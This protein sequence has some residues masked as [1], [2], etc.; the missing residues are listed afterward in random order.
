MLDLIKELSRDELFHFRK[1]AN[2][3]Y[4]NSNHHVAIVLEYFCSKYRG[5]SVEFPS[6]EFVFNKIFPGEKYNDSKFRKFTSDFAQAMEKFL[7]QREFDSDPV[8]NNV[9]LLKMLRLRGMK[10][11]FEMEYKKILRSQSKRFSRDESYYRNQTDL[12][13][14]YYSLNYSFP[15]KKIS[16]TLQEKSD[17]VDL[18]FIFSKLHCFNEMID[19]NLRLNSPLKFRLTFFDDVMNYVEKN[20]TEI[21]KKHPNVYIIYLR[22]RMV[23][24]MDDKYFLRLKIFLQEK[25][26]KFTNEKLC[27]YYNYIVSYLWLKINSGQIKYREELFKLYN[28][29][30]EKNLFLIDNKISE[31]EFTSVV[32][33]VLPLKKFKWIETFIERYKD[34]FE[35]LSGKDTYL[36]AKAKLLFYKKDFEQMFKH[37]SAVEIKGPVFYFNSKALLA[38]TYFDTGDYV[39][40]KYIADNLRQY[41]KMNKAVN[42]NQLM[43]ISVFN[44]YLVALLKI[45]NS[46]LDDAYADIAL[47]KNQLDNEGEFVPNKLWFYEKLEEMKSMNT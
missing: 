17:N 7:I 47:T 44:K 23:S 32:N 36:L 8:T 21:K 20:E 13:S 3:P 14:E 15:D 40:A 11:R 38:R 35:G 2:S 22:V 28:M 41:V 45:R 4:L 1:F 12:L 19:T 42:K 18:G 31:S 43:Q 37:L 10:K 27:Y 5:K 46:T 16:K 6:K 30:F 26:N 9:T 39:A 24:T 34:N 29:M 33:A 25:I